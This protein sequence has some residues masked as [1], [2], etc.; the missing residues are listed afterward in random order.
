[1]EIIIGGTQFTKNYFKIA[2]FHGGVN[3]LPNTVSPTAHK[4]T[5]MCLERRKKIV[6]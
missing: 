4:E 2:Q 1:M 3:G 6:Q 5:H